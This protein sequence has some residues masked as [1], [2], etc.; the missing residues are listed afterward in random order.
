MT[1]PADHAHRRRH[2]HGVT[3]DITDAGPGSPR[4]V[5]LRDPTTIE[6]RVEL[7]DL[8]WTTTTLTGK[9]R[10]EQRSYR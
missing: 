7:S 9:P 3:G 8:A 4:R 2:P 1:P 5:S 6:S 10:S